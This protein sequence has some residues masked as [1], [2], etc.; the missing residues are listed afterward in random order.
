MSQESTK[1]AL[2]WHAPGLT[3]SLLSVRYS[4]RHGRQRVFCVRCSACWTARNTGWGAQGTSQE[5]LIRPGPQNQVCTS[6]VGQ[7]PLPSPSPPM[8][9]V[10][11]P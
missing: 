11:C 4:S 2:A 9:D 3:A 1:L 10:S 5:V 6:P 8:E 7:S